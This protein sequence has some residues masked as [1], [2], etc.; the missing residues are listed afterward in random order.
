MKT[1]ST[2]VLVLIILINRIDITAQDTLSFRLDSSVVKVEDTFDENDT[3]DYVTLHTSYQYDDQNRLIKK[4]SELISEDY[5]YYSDSIVEFIEYKQFNSE[6][7]RREKLLKIYDKNKIKL[8]IVQAINSNDIF[9][10]VKKTVYFYD[11]NMKDTLIID[12]TWKD[13]KWKFSLKYIKKYDQFQN[14]IY[15]KNYAYSTSYE[16][17]QKNRKISE[18]VKYPPGWELPE[19]FKTTWHYSILDKLDSIKYYKSNSIALESWKCTRKKVYHY[20][21]ENVIRLEY[22]E[23]FENYFKLN[24]Y[25]LIYQGQISFSEYVDSVISVKILPDGT[26]KIFAKRIVQFSEMQDSSYYF[27]DEENVFGTEGNKYLI[28]KI[29]N[30]YNLQ[31]S[32]A[33]KNVPTIEKFNIYPQPVIPSEKLN[34]KTEINLEKLSF[35]I[36]DFSGRIVELCDFLNLFAPDVPGIYIVKIKDENKIIGYSKV[37]VVR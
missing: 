13:N 25:E 14:L 8:E 4:N 23:P 26:L 28:S 3:S 30:W 34:I 11:E 9:K 7:S 22:W 19:Y 36:I 16:Y 2:I 27:Q 5:S 32:T 6:I 24:S 29:Q 1:L 18:I 20:N 33:N 17:D 21:N 35:E 31:K 37:L 15:Y 10:N 12:S